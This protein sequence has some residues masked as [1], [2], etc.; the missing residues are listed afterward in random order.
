MKL[1]CHSIG[2]APTHF[3]A[4][5]SLGLNGYSTCYVTATL[6]SRPLLHKLN[7][8]KHAV[9]L[10][11]VA[12]QLFALA[13]N[14]EGWSVYFWERNKLCAMTVKSVFHVKLPMT[15]V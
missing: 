13:L 7:Y 14:Q 6:T 11:E 8:T 5:V 15:V 2:L 3:L 4:A 12:Q 1:S 9:Q 10:Q